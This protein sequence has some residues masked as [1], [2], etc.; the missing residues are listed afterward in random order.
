[1]DVYLAG[2]GYKQTI[3]QQLTPPTKETIQWMYI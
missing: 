1:M 2:E 3:I